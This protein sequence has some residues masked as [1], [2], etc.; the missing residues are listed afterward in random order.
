MRREREEEER[1]CASAATTLPSHTLSPLSPSPPQVQRYR[2][3]IASKHADVAADGGTDTASVA[4]GAT[5][6]AGPAAPAPPPAVMD[7]GA[8]AGYYTEKSPKALLAEWA[9]GAKRGRPRYRAK[10]EGG[11]GEDGAAAPSSS[12]TAKVVI[13]GTPGK[14]DTDTVAFSPRGET[15]PSAADAEQ[16][17]AVAGLH[18]VAGDRALHRILPRA[19]R[20]QWEAACE[21]AT[22]S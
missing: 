5:S 20:P 2:E 19:Y 21:A 7:V 11:G 1:K 18:A 4:S 6:T 12:F 3:H 14:P 8:K 22:P 9:A 13:P 15:Y 10:G 17:A 16:A